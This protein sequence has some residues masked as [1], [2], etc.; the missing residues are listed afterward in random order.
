MNTAPYIITK[1]NSHRARAKVFGVVGQNWGVF[2]FTE[3]SGG[4]L[5]LLTPEEFERV[6]SIKGVGKSRLK[7]SSLHSCWAGDDETAEQQRQTLERLKA[8]KQFELQY[9]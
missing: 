8:F 5:Y 9:S 3:R 4:G 6:K 7:A 1:C 2:S